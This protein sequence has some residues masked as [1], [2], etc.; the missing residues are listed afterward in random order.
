MQS[1]GAW[2][3]RRDRVFM[4][5]CQEQIVQN[6][7]GGKMG[8]KSEKKQKNGIKKAQDARKIELCSIF[9]AS[10]VSRFC[11]NLNQNLIS[12]PMQLVLGRWD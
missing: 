12:Y 5:A 1:L 6:K 7:N 3:I 10:L 8:T 4:H 2:L 9:L 11:S